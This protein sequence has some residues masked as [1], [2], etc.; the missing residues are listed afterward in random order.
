VTPR[1]LLSHVVRGFVMGAADIVPGVSGGTIALIL[2]I[3]ERLITSVR[4]GARALGR[5]LRGDI[6]GFATNLRAI[7]WSFIAPLLSGIGMAIIALS[8]I[9]ARLLDEQP[10]AMAGLF[11]GLV[12][13]S[14]IIAWRLLD[15]RDNV[16]MAVLA[17]VAVLAF[18][19]LGLQSGTTTS[20]SLLIFFFSGGLAIC[21][22]I[23][24]G[25]SGSFLL[26]MIG[27]YSAVVGAVH[28]RAFTEIAI[29]GL[30][31]IAG[32]ALF[33]TMLGYVLD[34]HRDTLL[35]ALIGLMAGSIR[36]LWPWPNG[37]GVIGEADEQIDGT[38]IE[39]PT[40]WADAWLP[41]VLALVAFLVV[42]GLDRFA[43]SGRTAG[44]A[45]L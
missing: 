16:R 31:A 14:I 29:F 45:A 21:A 15:R 41:L 25:V 42:I 18:A 13:A 23:L 32:L 36:V 27:M 24:P 37:V 2:G 20:P 4:S 26:L 38:G 1:A 30:G 19:L 33:S 35:A 11:L 12:M 39:W 28:D 8:S 10:E 34:H 3:Y 9:I 7:E 43:S 17:L 40:S 6:T 22:M 5:L 44:A